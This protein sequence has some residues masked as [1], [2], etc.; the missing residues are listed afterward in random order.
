MLHSGFD[1]ENEARKSSGSEMQFGG[2]MKRILCLSVF[3]LLLWPASLWASSIQCSQYHVALEGRSFKVP[4]YEFKDRLEMHKVDQTDGYD[5]LWKVDR[6]VQIIDSPSG[7]ADMHLLAQ[8]VDMPGGMWMICDYH[9]VGNIMVSDCRDGNYYLDVYKN[10]IGNKAANK[11]LGTIKGKHVEYNIHPENPLSFILSGDIKKPEHRTLEVQILPPPKYNYAFNDQKPGVLE[12]E[13]H[14]KVTPSDYEGDITWDVPQIEGS[15]M[16]MDPPS[17]KGPTLKIRYEGLPKDNSQFGPKTVK[18]FVDVGGCI[19][20]DYQEV[21]VF[22]DRDAK[23]N[24]GGEFPN[25]FYYWKQ[26][27]AGR[28]R[29]QQIIIKYG[30]TTFDLCSDGKIPA[31]YKP[32]SGH[33]TIYV[34]DLAK[35]GADFPTTFPRL[36]L[37]PP[38]YK[39]TRTTTQIDTFAVAVRHEYEHYQIE[40]NYRGGKSPED[41]TGLDTDGDGLPDNVEHQWGFSP[42]S[43]QTFLRAHPIVADVEEDEEWLCYMSMLEIPPGSLDRYDWA[44]PGKQWP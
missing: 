36:S 42:Y 29:N 24:P 43:K 5:G 4:G 8:R 20:D 35:L 13:F 40:F 22:Y 1:Q 16:T 10:K 39:G 11:W 23:N 27:P 31:L 14:A 41:Y 37:Q 18:V 28:P 34:C 26:T 3:L 6:I 25:W 30:G 32:G 44:H 2:G 19:A 17:G 15:E 21:K 38:Y 7:G 12:M 9:I 33:A